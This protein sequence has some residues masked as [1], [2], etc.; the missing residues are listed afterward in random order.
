MKKDIDKALSFFKESRHE[1]VIE[2]CKRILNETEN[3]SIESLQLIIKSLMANNQLEKARFY[4]KQALRIEPNNY[5]LIKDLGNS[6]LLEGDRDKAKNYYK[7]SIMIEKNYAPSL[8]NLGIIELN[9]GNTEKALSLLIRAIE[10][11][12]KLVPAWLNLASCYIDLDKMEE[13]EI[14]CRNALDLNYNLFNSHLLLSSILS[15]RTKYIEAEESIHEAIRLRPDS[16]ESYYN[17]GSILN[18]SG[19]SKES[20]NAFKKALELNPNSADSQYNIGNIL[21]N[22][23]E[24][25][26]AKLY[27][28]R[29]IDINPNFANAH[30][31]MGKIHKD[32]GDSKKAFDSYMRAIKINKSNS[33]YYSLIKNLIRDN[34]INEINKN[35]LK[36]ILNIL[37]KREDIPHEEIFKA[38]NFLYKDFIDD[39]IVSLNSEHIDDEFFDFF[40]GD[41]ILIQAIKNM[42]FR[43]IKWEILLNRIRKMLLKMIFNTETN[44]SNNKLEFI[45]GLAQQCFINEY[46]Y[47]L[48]KEE[49]NYIKK[50]I[51]TFKTNSMREQDMAILACYIPLHKLSKDIPSIKSFKSSNRSLNELIKIQLIEPLEE[52]KLSNKIISLGSIT[53][54]ISTK[55]KA[56]YENNPYPRWK[57]ENQFKEIDYTVKELINSEIIPNRINSNIESKPIKILLAGCGTGKQILHAQRYG[58]A[59]ITAID[60]S[61]SSLAFAQRK[62]NELGIKN[63]SLIQMDILEVALLKEKFDI[64]EC[65]GVL[66]HMDD[67]QKGLQSLL[68]VSRP[69]SFLKLS[70]Y[71]ELSRQNVIKARTIIRDRKLDP[72]IENIR[73][74]RQDIIS[75][76]Y[77]EIYSQ[78]TNIKSDFYTTSAFRD[79]VFHCQEHRFTCKQID[80]I[81]SNNQLKF[82]GYTNLTSQIRSLYKQNFPIDKAQTSLTNWGILESKYPGIFGG[83]PNFWVSKI[84]L[85]K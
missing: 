48:G 79:L 80:E 44:C 31:S 21:L 82:I 7:K 24:A 36:Y 12:P 61:R 56:Q 32:L 51:N 43:D 17:L 2:I 29:A 5:E 25:L 63:V 3:D 59:Q 73:V 1:E 77:P 66:H 78:T 47:N 20:I 70:F 18:S 38:L 34:D 60:L 4:L 72:D 26:E 54:N 33:I 13:A 52:E 83:T 40:V 15:K 75:G 57:F 69:N 58:N 37:L 16:S 8:T 67:P 41:Q 6:Y 28:N 76:K 50:M 39:H 53:D 85:L 46:V 55:V 84:N 68:E 71:S 65:V 45:I 64:I 81:L 62:I 9:S 49:E 74:L 23:G 22:Y 19:K 11:D 27:I 10:S 42:L 35:E 30:A 14:S